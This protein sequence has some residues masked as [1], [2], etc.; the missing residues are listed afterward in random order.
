M[1][2]VY[3]WLFVYKEW[4]KQERKP[5]QDKGFE[6]SFRDYLC[7]HQMNFDRVSNVRD[8]GFG[9]SYQTLSDIPH[10]LDVI[11]VRGSEIHSPGDDGN[12]RSFV[13]RSFYIITR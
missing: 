8:M 1:I 2:E 6:E 3:S 9:L 4:S 7:R 11:C 5:L 10:E 13:V 12:D